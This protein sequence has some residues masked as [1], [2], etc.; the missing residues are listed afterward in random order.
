[1]DADL[2]STQQISFTGNL[3]RD[4]NTQMFFIIEKAKET[5]LDFSKVTVNVLPFYFVLI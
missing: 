4:G 1:M 5:V 3:E 2:K